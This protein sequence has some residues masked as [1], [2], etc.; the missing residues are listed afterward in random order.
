MIEVPSKI[1]W[2]D[3]YTN[4]AYIPDGACYP[5]RWHKL[6][7]EFRAHLP[8]HITMQRDIVYGPSPRAKADFF[9]PPNPI[10]LFVFVH[11]GYWMRF[12]KHDWSHLARGALESNWAVAMPGY[13]LTPEISI[14]G[15]A[16]EITTAIA[17]AANLA[18]GP[19]A[20]AGHSAGGHLVT[21]AAT[22]DANLPD[23]VRQRIHRVTSISGLHDLRPL[24]QTKMNQTLR[25]TEDEAIR[26]SPA[27]HQP[28]SH[29]HYTAWAGAD[30]RPEFIRQTRLLAAAW[31]KNTTLHIEE[32]KHHF[33]VIDD[34]SDSSSELCKRLFG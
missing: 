21:Q 7:A 8:N 4:G 32:N 33:N 11:G 25:L 5:E 20:L 19:I 10:G 24:L 34:L 22:T 17:H 2:D 1:D 12:S 31:A 27:L 13:T 29:I 9:T 26:Q 18:T 28:L 6:A 3:A 15:I 23:F 14:T 16:Q 30:E